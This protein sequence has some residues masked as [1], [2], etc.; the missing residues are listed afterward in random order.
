MN[1]QILFLHGA[2]ATKLQFIQIINELKNEYTCHTINFAGHGG[3]IIPVT[4]LTFDTFSNNI[5]NYLNTNNIDKINLFGYSMGG[6][7]ALYFACKYPDRVE[8]VF[9]INVKFNWDPVSTAKEIGMLNPEKMLEKIP[10]F[11][12]NLMVV[13]GL[14]IWKNLLHSTS[15]MMQKLSETVLL[16]KEQL[17]SIKCPVLVSVGDRDTTSSLTETIDVYK[18]LSNAQLLVLPNSPHPFERVNMQ[19]LV[20]AIKTFF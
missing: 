20:H 18:T 14:N 19:V 9:T 5:L 10:A 16:T 11:A 1:K 15:E 8:K 2:L 3:E 17:A 13:H 4:G 7:A 6:Y 12:N